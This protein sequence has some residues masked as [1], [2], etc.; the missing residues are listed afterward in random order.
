[1]TSGCEVP[2]SFSLYSPEN[3]EYKP[4]SNTKKEH[5]LANKKTTFLPKLATCARTVLSNFLLGRKKTYFYLKMLKQFFL[6]PNSSYWVGD[7]QVNSSNETMHIAAE[8]YT[9]AESINETELRTAIPTDHP[10]ENP[11]TPASL[12]LEA[13]IPDQEPLNKQEKNNS[14]RLT[15]PEPVP[16]EE[17]STEPSSVLL[18]GSAPGYFPELQPLGHREKEETRANQRI[19]KFPLTRSSDNET[20]NITNLRVYG[21]HSFPEKH[22]EPVPLEHINLQYQDEPYMQ[23]EL[24]SFSNNYQA[25][26]RNNLAH[27][28]PSA[29]ENDYGRGYEWE[30]GREKKG[31]V[32]QLILGFLGLGRAG[33]GRKRKQILIWISSILFFLF[34]SS[35]LFEVI[36]HEKISEGVLAVII[37]EIYRRWEVYKEEFWQNIASTTYEVLE[38]VSGVQLSD[39]LD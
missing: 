8:A 23:R 38:N 26:E 15:I 16:D 27:T 33:S 31:N 32:S 39:I 21:N 11:Y 9:G 17:I 1:M 19:A 14:E 30:Y 24:S 28:L 20:S 3:W 7:S 36:N 34:G 13:Q 37:Y 6:N 29:S 35:L 22:N 2:A 25:D 4:R 18:Y 10:T 5:G 12:A